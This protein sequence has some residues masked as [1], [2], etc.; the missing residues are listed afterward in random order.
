[1][2]FLWFGTFAGVCWRIFQF[3]VIPKIEGMLPKFLQNFIYLDF[4]LAFSEN[5][6]KLIFRETTVPVCGP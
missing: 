3:W 4:K 6:L 1:M 2:G 5:A